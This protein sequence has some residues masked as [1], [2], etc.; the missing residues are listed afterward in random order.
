M[1]GYQEM[2]H[3]QHIDPGAVTRADCVSRKAKSSHPINLEECHR[4]VHFSM[5]R[6][7]TLLNDH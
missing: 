2:D 3:P 1:R 7:G 4:L 5:T 6:T